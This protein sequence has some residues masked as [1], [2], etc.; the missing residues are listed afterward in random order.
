VVVVERYL[1]GVLEQGELLKSEREAWELSIRKLDYWL[2]I[3]FQL[4]NHA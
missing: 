1:E 2:P 4:L 3:A